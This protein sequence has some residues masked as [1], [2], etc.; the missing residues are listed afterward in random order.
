M[1][2]DKPGAKILKILLKDFTV[3]PTITA[4]AEELGMSRVGVWKVLKKLEAEK[5]AVLSPIGAGKTSTYSISLNWDNPLTEK[6]LALALTEDALENQRWRSNFAELEKKVDFLVIYGSI[7]HSP[8][9]A[10][11]IDILSVVSNKNKFLDID[12]SIRKTQKT[13][14]KKIHSLSFTQAEFKQ[15]LEKPNKVFIDAV[16]KGIILF[17]QEKFIAFIRSVAKR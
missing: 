7:I 17:G 8:K 5:L 3:K 16:K 14:I 2:T 4:L 12:E 13:Q 6:N 9:E 11:D 10:D 15:E 1:K